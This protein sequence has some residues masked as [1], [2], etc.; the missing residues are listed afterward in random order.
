MQFPSINEFS[1]GVPSRE[2]AIASLSASINAELRRVFERERGKGREHLG[3]FLVQWVEDFVAEDLNAAGYSFGR[4]E[5]GGDVNFEDSYQV[6]GNGAVM[7][8][9]LI[10]EFRGFSCTVSWAEQ[11]LNDA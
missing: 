10:L 6:F 1:A 8:T 9:G 4:L 11:V 7:G 5:Y 3:A 2:A